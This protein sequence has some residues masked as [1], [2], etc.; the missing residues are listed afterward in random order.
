MKVF[1]T[2]NSTSVTTGSVT[3]S[4]GIGIMKDAYIGENLHV[5]NIYAS[6][7]LPNPQNIVT[8]PTSTILDSHTVGISPFASSG[9]SYGSDTYSTTGDMFGYMGSHEHGRIVVL[10]IIDF[11]MTST[12][13]DKFR[14]L[15]QQYLYPRTIKIF[16]IP[17]INGSSSTVYTDGLMTIDTSGNIT[18]SK[19]DGANFDGSKIGFA[20]TTVSYITNQ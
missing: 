5:P 1:L 4:G 13:S 16:I 9:W 8:T 15:L 19:L 12:G 3:I 11:S 20:S 18:I 7:T 17:I 14:I 10:D 2:D 6:I